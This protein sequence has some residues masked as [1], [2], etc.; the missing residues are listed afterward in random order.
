MVLNNRNMRT[1]NQ[2]QSGRQGNIL[3]VTLLTCVILGITLAS[4]LGLVSNQNRSVMRS[5]AWNTAIPVLE[6]GIEEALTHLKHHELGYLAGQGWSSSDGR[7]YAKEIR[8]DDSYC[9]VAIDIADPH[10]ETP[11]IYSSAFV[12]VPL[13]PSS[14]AGVV[15]A[16]LGPGLNETRFAG[17]GYLKRQAR[18]KTARDYLFM[19]AMVADQDI[20]LKGNNITTD[21]FVSDDPNYSTNGKY[22]PALARDNGD[23]ATNS[24]LKDVLNI[25]NADIKGKLST[26]P[27]VDPDN[28][29]YRI[30]PNGSVGSAEFVEDSSNSGKIEDGYYTDDMNMPLFDVIFEHSVDSSATSYTDDSGTMYEYHLHSTGVYEIHN[31]KKGSIL[32]SQPNTVLLVTGDLSISGQDVIR[33]LP[34]ASLKLYVA[35]KTA[36]IG[37]QGIANEAGSVL[38]FA[39]YGLPSNEVLKISGNGEFIGTI[40][41][42]SADFTLSGGGSSVQD[43]IGASVTKSVTMNGHFNFHYD[44]VLGTKGP[45]QGYIP[46]SWDEI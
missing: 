36:T 14:Q 15:Q 6:A 16:Q 43:F 24:N 29:P 5:L 8:I 13:H 9:I 1:N 21:S 22:D 34:G 26:G 33:I 37:G 27:M 3:L 28:P 20:D 41:A 38:A 11:V 32:V 17:G 46:I 45:F 30:G 35:A 12:P 19:K 4:Y 10:S 18:V 2:T 31:L 23:V 39:Y 42:P 44:E 40:Y 7:Y 25:G